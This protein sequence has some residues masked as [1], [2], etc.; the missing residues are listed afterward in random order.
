MDLNLIKSIKTQA[1]AR[2]A[3]QAWQQGQAERSWSYS[4]LSDMQDTFAT[5]AKK[6]KLTDEFKENGII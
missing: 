3:A 5:L 1:E 6:F 4:E 2:D